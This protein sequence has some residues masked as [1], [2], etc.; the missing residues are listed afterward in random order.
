M[1]AAAGQCHRP[2]DG[3]QFLQGTGERQLL[4]DF[5]GDVNHAHVHGHADWP[6]AAQCPGQGGGEPEQAGGVQGA[7]RAARS[8]AASMRPGVTI[9]GRTAWRPS[10]AARQWYS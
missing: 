10:M 8:V 2:E 9:T 3:G 1:S 5:L 4:L 6:V 7:F